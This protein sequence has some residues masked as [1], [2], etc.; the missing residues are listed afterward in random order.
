[1]AN[2]F[3]EIFY[4]IFGIFSTP[5]TSATLDCRWRVSCLP[6]TTFCSSYFDRHRRFKCIFQ[7]RQV[8]ASEADHPNNFPS[9]RPRFWDSLRFSPWPWSPPVL[10]PFPTK[11]SSCFGHFLASHRPNTASHHPRRIP[12]STANQ[13]HVA[14]STITTRIISSYSTQPG[15]DFPTS[16]VF[17][18]QPTVGLRQSLLATCLSSPGKSIWTGTNPWLLATIVF[19][20]QAPMALVVPIY[21][22]KFVCVQHVCMSVHAN[23][24]QPLSMSE[25]AESCPTHHLTRIKLTRPDSI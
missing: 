8:S 12:H 5:S 23:V 21:T 22:L 24:C 3:S 15:G 19:W 25:P 13:F 14:L 10:S 11:F 9:P 16:Q 7:Y 4:L 18:A 2:H 17:F 20:Q 6:V 1:M